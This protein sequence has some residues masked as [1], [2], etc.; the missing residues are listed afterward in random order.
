M[1]VDLL[2][3]LRA[4]LEEDAAAAAEMAG[5]REW[6]ADCGDV[7]DVS[8]QTTGGWTFTSERLLAEVEAK[9]GMITQYEN[10]S[11]LVNEPIPTDHHS[12]SHI[13]QWALYDVLRRLAVP[14]ASHPD[15]REK[16]R[17]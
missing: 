3:F 2:A 13:E 14:H 10:V 16:W 17:L 9:R 7:H 15:Y 8:I 5:N 1:T 11:K 12:A 6:P 4:R